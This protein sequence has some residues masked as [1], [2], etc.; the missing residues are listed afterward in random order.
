MS[1]TRLERQIRFL[2]EVD[3][4]KEV[5]RRSYLLTSQRRENDSEHSWHLAVMAMVLAE[6]ADDPVDGVRAVK[7]CLV[8]DIV[9][10]DAGDTYC[11][12]E[13]GNEDKAE[14]ERRAAERLF[15][16]LPED[17]GLELRELWQEFEQGRSPEARF[18]RAVDRL[19]PL[20]HNFHT[21]GRSWREHGIDSELV[22]DRMLPIRESSQRLWGYA[23]EVIRE[24]VERGYLRG[25]ESDAQ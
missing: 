2:L 15:G 13:A 14:R 23:L 24:S 17:Q 3:K 8:H 10:I 11:Y 16:L 7:M 12:D 22:R 19:M 21:R 18:A 1:E 6:H 20:L 5:F 25:T 4:L 9:E